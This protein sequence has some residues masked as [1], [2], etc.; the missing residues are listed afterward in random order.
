[1]SSETLL[2]IGWVRCSLHAEVLGFSWWGRCVLLWSEQTDILQT[3]GKTHWVGAENIKKRQWFYRWAGQTREGLVDL[4]MRVR[5]LE[6]ER[7]F[8]FSL[9]AECI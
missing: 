9:A 6:K 1:M 2:V 5:L 4:V 7:L 3:G 8:L